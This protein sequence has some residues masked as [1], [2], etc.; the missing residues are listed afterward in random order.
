MDSLSHLEKLTKAELEAQLSA[1]SSLFEEKCKSFEKTLSIF[2]P[3][4]VKSEFNRQHCHQ[5]F[6]NVDDT[7]DKLMDLY[8]QLNIIDEFGIPAREVSCHLQ[9]DR[10]DKLHW[11]LCLEVEKPMEEEAL[12][13]EPVPSLPS[14]TACHQLPPV[15]PTTEDIRQPEPVDTQ[16]V[17]SSAHPVQHQRHFSSLEEQQLC[18]DSHYLYQ[19]F[20]QQPYPE[21]HCSFK[22]FAQDCPQFTTS[23]CD[24][25][26]WSIRAQVT[27]AAV[28]RNQRGGDNLLLCHGSG[29]GPPSTNAF[30]SEHAKLTPLWHSAPRSSTDTPVRGC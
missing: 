22:R 1:C 15:Q 2:S 19:D 6:Q 3:S 8:L 5:S 26:S 21:S 10:L 17:P 12:L 30:D 18:P 27:A 24:I 29:I 14:D 7:M 23:L 13:P 20:A 9:I 16:S 25:P 11:R 28:E 4:V